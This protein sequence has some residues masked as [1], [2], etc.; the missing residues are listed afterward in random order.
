MKLVIT[1][2]LTILCSCSMPPEDSINLSALYKEAFWK[3]KRV[4][5]IDMNVDENND[6]TLEFFLDYP[7]Q[8]VEVRLKTSKFSTTFY[9][10]NNNGTSVGTKFLPQISFVDLQI[11]LNGT[12]ITS[13]LLKECNDTKCT[14][15]S[16]SLLSF[17]GN[18]ATD[19]IYLNLSKLDKLTS[20]ECSPL[21]VNENGI[22]RLVF[23]EN[24]SGPLGKKTGGR[25]SAQ[26]IVYNRTYDVAD[27]QNAFS[28]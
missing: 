27:I 23:K 1:I 18:I 8:L 4:S 9:T 24:F 6:V 15:S 3:T 10:L 20:S 28:K 5:T 22:N 21:V 25:L 17:S 11:E 16:S 14:G 13:C 12:N 19:E 7:G 2:F 26:V